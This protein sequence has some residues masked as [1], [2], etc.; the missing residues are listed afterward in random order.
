MRF[1]DLYIGD[2]LLAGAV[3]IGNLRHCSGSIPCRSKLAVNH[4]NRFLKSC[5]P[6]NWIGVLCFLASACVA[7]AAGA[8]KEPAGEAE[9]WAFQ[10]IRRPAQPAVQDIK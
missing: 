10:P 7:S 2:I 8:P 6:A 5:T 3:G 4:T 1:P 9:H